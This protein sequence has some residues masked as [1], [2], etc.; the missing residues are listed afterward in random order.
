MTGNAV[1][2]KMVLDVFM[3]RE[4]MPFKMD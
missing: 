2:W 4:E 3:G 1:P